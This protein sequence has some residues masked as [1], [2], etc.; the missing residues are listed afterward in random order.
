MLLLS[1][2]L[3]LCTISVIHAVLPSPFPSLSSPP[4]TPFPPFLSLHSAFFPQ[5]FGNSQSVSSADSAESKSHSASDGKHHARKSGTKKRNH[6]RSRSN[7]PTPES[8]KRRRYSNGSTIESRGEEGDKRGGEP[9]VFTFDT[10]QLH[11]SHRV[12]PPPPL[13]AMQDAG[14]M[15]S[16]GKGQRNATL[17]DLCRA[18]EALEKMENG[19]R[20]GIPLPK[21]ISDEEDKRR[22][23]N[24][25]IPT[26]TSPQLDR[27]RHKLGSTPPYTP[28]P[29]LS[30]ARSMTMLATPG[31]PGGTSCGTP[32][33][34]LQSW[35]CRRTSDH[36]KSSEVEDGYPEPKINVGRHFQAVLPT[37]DG[38]G[39]G[40]EGGK[41][42]RKREVCVISMELCIHVHINI[43]GR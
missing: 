31:T 22:P 3:H 8:G 12:M 1:L 13:A 10:S 19:N 37:C 25:H 4:S 35:S 34:I 43:H 11:P 20:G 41:D 2:I 7:S 17:D 38:K 36:R 40:E 23:G 26:H 33:R 30:P 5:P 28:P 6:S 21:E 32:S 9:S 27:D 18:V 15:T 14:T 42:G 24:I 39:E 29:I 16:Q